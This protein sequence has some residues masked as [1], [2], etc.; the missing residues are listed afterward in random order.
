LTL[1]WYFTF[2]TCLATS[3][4]LLDIRHS[5]GVCFTHS[6]PHSLSFKHDVLILAHGSLI[7]LGSETCRAKGTRQFFCTSGPASV[8]HCVGNFVFVIFSRRAWLLR[9]FRGSPRFLIRLS[10]M[11]DG[12]L[13]PRLWIGVKRLVRMIFYWRK[14]LMIVEL[15][16]YAVLSRDHKHVDKSTIHVPGCQGDPKLSEIWPRHGLPRSFHRLSPCWD[17]KLPVPCDTQM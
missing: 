4:R 7:S 3:I 2:S 10:R 1:R 13:L 6:S 8:L 11:E 9:S 5:S 16:C 15:R 12:R 17:W 14:V